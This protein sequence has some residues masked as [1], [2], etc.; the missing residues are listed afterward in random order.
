MQSSFGQLTF[1]RVLLA[2]LAFATIAQAEPHLRLSSDGGWTL[3]DEWF[4]GFS[5]LEMN[6]DGTAATLITDKGTLVSVALFRDEGKISGVQLRQS[7]TIKHGNGNRLRGLSTD[8]EG[9][10]IT[11][12]GTA[13]I[14]FEQRHRVAKLNLTTGR[15]RPLPKAATFGSFKPNAGLEALAVHPNGTLYTLPEQSNSR[16]TAFDLHA[17]STQG[18]RITHKLPR[19]GPFLPV[20]ADFDVSGLMYLLERAATP[21]GFRTR[22]RRFNLASNALSEE[23]LLTTSPN[24]FDN[25]EALSV[26]QDSDG[27]TR[28]TMVSDDNFL[29]IQRTQIVEYI[30][31]D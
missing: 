5:G 24:R 31:N 16:S 9:L 8:A 29:R 1:L 11:A 2:G 3:R 4:G 28:L 6:A 21:L 15:T 23:T 18:W 25:L 10:A 20:G 13:F 7:I 22:I 30:L 12:D 17:Y 14:S 26:W 19:R 27:A